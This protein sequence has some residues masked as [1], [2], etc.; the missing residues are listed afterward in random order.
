MIKIYCGNDSE[1]FEIFNFYQFVICA[2]FFL[3][4]M[5][6]FFST[7]EFDSNDTKYHFVFNS[8]PK[9]EFDVG[10]I[11]V[12]LSEITTV[13]CVIFPYFLVINQ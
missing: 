4:A 1:N 3:A 9:D 7:N 10:Q 13:K 5:E 11:D 2:Y 6:M 12:I 8:T